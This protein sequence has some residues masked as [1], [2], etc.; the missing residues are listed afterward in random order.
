LNR[1]RIIGDISLV[2]IILVM[3]LFVILEVDRLIEF[4][5]GFQESRIQDGSSEPTEIDETSIE[6]P[7]GLEETNAP[8]FLD[9]PEQSNHSTELAIDFE[10]LDLYGESVA[11]SDFQG[12]A[13]MINFWATWCPPCRAEM[14]L[15]Q[16]FADRHETELVVLAINAGEEEPTVQQFVN[17][18]RYEMLFLLDQTNSVATMYRV[19]G[20]PTSLFIDPD[21][22]LQATH[23]GELSEQLLTYYLNHKLRQSIKL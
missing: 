21:G 1:K 17:E 14:P 13:V 6:E 9:D 23:I 4:F 15:I 22:V 10:L 18:F 16:E 20:F 11:L 19:R 3:G 8:T 7:L 2:F 5:Q 12:K